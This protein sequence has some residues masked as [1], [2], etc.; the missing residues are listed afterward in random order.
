M[1]DSQSKYVDHLIDVR[2]HKVSTKNVPAIF[3]DDGFVSIDG[4]ADTTGGKPI[5]F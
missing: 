1:T 3:L 5:R 2:P 4:L